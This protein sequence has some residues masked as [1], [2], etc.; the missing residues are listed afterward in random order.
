[1]NR[2]TAEYVEVYVDRGRVYG[3][4]YKQGCVSLC[5]FSFVLK[6]LFV[7]R[8]F[9]CKLVCTSALPI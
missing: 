8:G 2:L 4:S 6:L 9:R 5:R 3:L 7:F 1:M